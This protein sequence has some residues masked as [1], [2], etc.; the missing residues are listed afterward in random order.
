M[1]GLVGAYNIPNASTPAKL[2]LFGLQ[3]RGREGGGIA[4]SDGKKINRVQGFGL[5]EQ[6]LTGVK[7]KARLPGRIAVG[8]NRYSTAGAKGSLS[9]LQPFVARTASFQI[10]VA[11]NGN[12]ENADEL[13]RRLESHGSILAST[14]DSE[15]FPH[16]I[17][18]SKKRVFRN[19]LIEAM[20]KAKGAYSL[21]VMTRDKLYAAVDRY[22]FRPLWLARWK[23]GVLFASETCAFAPLGIKRSEMREIK[24][25]EL[26]CVSGGNA[27][28]AAKISARRFAAAPF[29]RHCIFELMY[30]SQPQSRS[31]GE[32]V[33][34]VRERLGERLA[35]RFRIDGDFVLAVPD[36][37]NKQGERYASVSGITFRQGLFRNHHSGRTF[38]QSTGLERTVGVRMKFSVAEGMYAGKTVIVIDDSLV[39]STTMKK[40]VRLLRKAGAAKVIVLIASPPVISRCRWGI[41][42]ATKKELVAATHSVEEI[43]RMIGADF[44]GYLTVPDV[45]EAVGDPCGRKYCVSCFTGKH[46]YK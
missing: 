21:L 20:R 45:L 4:S 10:A 31:W 6:F 17:A 36:S 30:F 15:C 2:M 35:R 34:E 12:L 26:V 43:R 41:D 9:C 13:R 37:S 38:I 46:P 39:R 22:G 11:H 32:E 33:W 5:V 24:P 18:R 25:G 19:R 7:M 28:T 23:K 29:T 8:H 44:L 1:C 3:S 27:K 42:M 14:S 40:V 16:L